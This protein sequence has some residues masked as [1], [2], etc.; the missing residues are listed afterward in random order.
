MQVTINGKNGSYH[1]EMSQDS[2][3]SVYMADN[4]VYFATADE[5]GLTDEPESVQVTGAGYDWAIPAREVNLLTLLDV[6]RLYDH[7]ASFTK[8]RKYFRQHG[9]KCISEGGQKGMNH[10][11]L[12][13][14][15]RALDCKLSTIV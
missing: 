12:R 7:D 1:P 8:V 5:L 13:C 2:T 14:A 4:T 3:Y 11:Q 9:I 10:F 6:R 15:L